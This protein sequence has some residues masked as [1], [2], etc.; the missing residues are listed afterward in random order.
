MVVPES[1]WGPF[2][3]G[4]LR[5]VGR[6]GFG[7]QAMTFQT[8]I[9]NPRAAVELDRRWGFRVRPGRATLHLRQ[10]RIAVKIHDERGGRV[11]DS[12]M[13]DCEGVSGSDIQYIAGMH[14]VR[15]R[16]D[17][18]MVLVQADP[19]YVFTKVDRGFSHFINVDL[20]GGAPNAC[21]C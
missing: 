20:E 7:P 16:A 3:A 9:D 5:L 11:P 1:P 14:L 8:Y 15:N 12:E 10:K 19:D 17:G 6:A 13:I 4:E 21:S 2:S 18:R